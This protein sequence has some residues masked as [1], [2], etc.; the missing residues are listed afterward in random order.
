[1][2]NYISLSELFQCLVW[3]TVVS[4]VII[5]TFSWVD[6]ILSPFS[7]L[8]NTVPVLYTSMIASEQNEILNQITLH[9]DLYRSIC[10]VNRAYAC[11]RSN[12]L[13]AFLNLNQLDT[14]DYIIERIDNTA[15]F[16][17][18]YKI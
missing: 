9:I 1:M 18:R 14:D 6:F 15:V 4:N 5:Y 7:I 12:E 16:H 17:I 8:R 2:Q 11:V 3:K 13:L 10:E